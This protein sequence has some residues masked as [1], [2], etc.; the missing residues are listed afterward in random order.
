M[1]Y[2]AGR[3][4][5]TVEQ[6]DAVIEHAKNQ[7]EWSEEMGAS[8]LVRGSMFPGMPPIRGI[9]EMVRAEVAKAFA[10]RDAADQT[11]KP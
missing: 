3:S 10:E 8:R 2:H 6:L 4:A 9:G 1:V 5:V 7:A 11:P